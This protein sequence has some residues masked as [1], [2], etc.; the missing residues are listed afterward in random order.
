M[1]SASVRVWAERFLASFISRAQRSGF[2]WTAQRAKAH[3]QWVFLSPSGLGPAQPQF[4]ALDCGL[5]AGTMDGRSPRR[6][7]LNSWLLRCV[8][9]LRW[10][11]LFGVPTYAC[12]CSCSRL[13]R[14][15]SCLQ[16]GT[17][18]TKATRW[19]WWH[20]RLGPTSPWILRGV[21]GGAR[22]RDA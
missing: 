16:N 21:H 14:V 4:Q 9:T 13:P 12:V 11:R 18:M 5:Q 6:H 19:S 8:P 2:L 17:T 20:Y 10:R 7:V 22:E 3:Q 15:M 1:T